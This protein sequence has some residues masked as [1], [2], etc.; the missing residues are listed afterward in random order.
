VPEGEFTP[1]I[2]RLYETAR[3]GPG[4]Q[5]RRVTILQFMVGKFGPFTA[6]IDKEEFNTA[7]AKEKMR[8]KAQQLRELQEIPLG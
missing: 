5:V 4:N 6:E 3:P 1:T 2:T 8:E 7:W